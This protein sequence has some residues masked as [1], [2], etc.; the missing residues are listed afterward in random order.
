MGWH[1]TPRP[2]PDKLKSTDSAYIAADAP[3]SLWYHNWQN[4]ESGTW[5]ATAEN[6]LS[7]SERETLKRRTEENREA[8][9]AE[10][11]YTAYRMYGT[12]LFGGKGRKVCTR[13]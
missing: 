10:R 13:A 5:T 11:K 2:A 4:G 3:V 6:K 9:E 8:A 12:S 7:K 1:L